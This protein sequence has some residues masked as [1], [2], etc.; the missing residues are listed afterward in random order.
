[1]SG[2]A[3]TYKPNK[4]KTL[5]DEHNEMDKH[6]DRIEQFNCKKVLV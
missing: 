3:L 6:T 1:M 5:N 2:N 4:I